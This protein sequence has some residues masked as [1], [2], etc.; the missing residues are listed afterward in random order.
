MLVVYAPL[1]KSSL[2]LFEG[3]MMGGCRQY[4]P[5]PEP[6]AVCGILLQE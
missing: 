6:C 4:Q 5:A 3:V 1:E 2:G